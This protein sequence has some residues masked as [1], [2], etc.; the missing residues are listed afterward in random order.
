MATARARVAAL[1]VSGADLPNPA[2][3]SP[4]SADEHYSPT[5]D[6]NS[7]GEEEKLAPKQAEEEASCEVEE[8]APQKNEQL[9]RKDT[10]APRPQHPTAASDKPEALTEDALEPF[11]V[12]KPPKRRKPQGQHLSVAF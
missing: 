8:G 2:C 10:E 7:Q 1:G 9:E 4:F 12:L 3:T 6:N 5:P 11:H